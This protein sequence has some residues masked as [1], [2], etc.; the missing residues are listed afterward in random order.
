[1]KNSSTPLSSGQERL[2]LVQQLDRDSAAY[3][4]PI[5]LRFRDGIDFEVLDRALAALVERHSAL[6][7]VFVEDEAG[8]PVTR[9][10]PGFRVPVER[11]VAEDAEEGWRPHGEQ[12]AAEPF[13]L[14]AAPPVRALVVECG[15][16]SAVLC[17][18]VHHIVIDGRSIR[19]LIR[20][21]IALYNAE[22]LVPLESTYADFVAWQRSVDGAA[23]EAH[24]DHWRRELDGFEPLRLPLDRPRSAD[25]G[26][27]GGH[28]DFAL[29]AE[30]TATLSAL[31]LRN[32]CT[33][34]S[35]VAAVFQA[36][37]SL[38]SGQQ[39]VTT[40]SV[41]S[42]R[43]DAR[44]AD[45]V[46]FF[47][48]TVVLR[49]RIGPETCL[50]DL[51]KLAHLK[52]TAAHVHQQAP[53]DQVVAAVQPDRE[54]GSNA[55]FDVVFVHHGETS[56]LTEG[57]ISRV[58]WTAAAT[59][60]DLELSTH[61]RR[62]QLHGT[63]TFRSGLFHRATAVR[64]T[65]RFVTLVEQ[66]LLQPDVPISQLDLISADELA[67]TEA[68]WHS[69]RRAVAG[70]TVAALFEAQVERTPDAIAVVTR[71]ERFTYAQLDERA[72]R[73]A[74]AL[75]AAGA[76]AEDVIGVLAE[77]GSDV[78]TAF[79]AILKTGAAYLPLATDDPAVRTQALLREAG[80][81]LALSDE[82][83]REFDDVVLM[84]FG[85]EGFPV[86]APRQN[87]HPDQLAYVM[88]TSG[89]TG[90]PK[91]VAVSHRQVA[92]LALDRG[93]TEATRR[94]LH[95]SPHTFDA[96]TFEIWVPLLS[97][98]C[99]VLAAPGRL[100]AA[101]FERLVRQESVTCAWLT[102]GLFRVFADERPGAF[103]GLREVW[104]GGDV[105]PPDAVAEVLRRHRHLVVV[106]GYGPTETT[107]FAT[108]HRVRE[109]DPA[110]GAIP[111]G[112]PLDNT[113]CHVLN[114]NLRPVPEG[115]AGELFIA[116]TGVGRGYLGRPDLTATRFV[117]DP[118]GPP[119][120]RMYRSGDLA[121]WRSDGVLE[122]L[123]RA[124]GQVKIRGYRV[125]TG[126]VEHALASLPGIRQAVVVAHGDSDKVLVA[127]VVPESAHGL[128]EKSLRDSLGEVLPGHLVPSAFVL[129]DQVPV[130]PNGKVDRRAL[131]E[132]SRRGRT[133]GR[134]PRS[135][136]EELLC[137]LFA[138][139]LGEEAVGV[140]DD[141]FA[142]G[143][144]SLLAARLVNRVRVLFDAGL[145]VRDI[146]ENTTPARLAA[147]LD[148]AA[149]AR[150]A[151]TVRP[152]PPRVPLSSA[153]QR[154]WFIHQAQGPNPT[155]NIP[156]AQR[157]RGWLDAEALRAALLDVVDRHESL[158]TV[159]P[160]ENGTPHQV[161]LPL[162]EVDSERL[163][164]VVDVTEAV[165]QQALDVAARHSFDLR[166]DVPV[167]ARLFRLSPDDHVLLVLIH[168]I[169]GDGW[170]IGPFHRDL[171]TAY[172][173]RTAGRKPAW[174]PLPV[175]YADFSLWERDVLGEHAESA[176]QARY[177]SDQLAGLPVELALPVD[178]RR[179]TDV[180]SDGDRVPVD[181]DPELHG[182][183][184][185]LAV[186]RQASL[187]MV[188]QA[189][190]AVL[191]SKLGGGTDIPLGGVVAG[192]SDEAL[193][194]LIGFFVNAQVL[195][196]DLSGTPTFGEV[197]SEVRR[198]NLAAYHHQD[199]AFE[200]VVEIVSPPRMLTRHPLFQVVLAFQASSDTAFVVDGLT[201]E[202]MQAHVRTAKF[203]LNFS[204][205]ERTDRDGAPL[206][207]RGVLEYDTSLFD[208][209]TA[210]RISGLLVGLLGAL[211]RHA[212][213][214][215]HHADMGHA[216]DAQLLQ[217]WNDTAVDVPPSTLVELIE[218]QVARTPD[219][220]AVLFEDERLSFAELDSRANRLASLLVDRGAGPERFVGVALPRSVDLVVTLVAV[221]KAGAAY[222]PIET[223]QPV[224]RVAMLLEESTPIAVVARR[225]TAGDVPRDAPLVVIDDEHV[226]AALAA[227]TGNP[228]REPLSPQHPAYLIYT[229]GSTGRPKGVL[230]SHEAIVNRLEWMQ[231]KFG[232][233][234]DDRVLQKTPFGFDVS[235]W[236]FF[237]PLITGAALVVARPDGHRDPDYLATLIRTEGVTTVHFVPSM[238]QAF[239]SGRGAAGCTGLRRVICSGE[240]LPAALADRFHEILPVP[241]HNLYGPT[242]AA[243]DVTSWDCEPGSD[244]ASIPIGAPVWNTRT[245][246]LDPL[247]RPVPIGVQ[248]ELYLSGVQVARGYVGKPDLTAERFVAD[249]FGPPGSRMYRTGDV[250]RWTSGGALEY[251]G[252][253]DD[254]VKIRGM[255]VEPEEI[256][257]VLSAHEAV[258]HAV[259]VPRDN[260]LVA[261]VVPDAVNAGA[262]RDLLAL[263]RTGE[264][265]GLPSRE[266]PNGMV[267]LGRNNAEIEFLHQEIFERREY[268][269]YG[270][271]LPDDAVVF[272]IGAH[273]GLFSLF[274]AHHAPDAT[275]YAFEPIPDLARELRLNTAVNGVR[276]HLFEC[277]VGQTAGEA[278]F[279]Y[280]PQLSMLSG[281]FGSE[282]EERAVV[283]AYALRDAE[284][285][286]TA[287]VGDLVTERLRDRRELVCSLRAVS[288]VI[289]EHQVE[290]I[291]LLKVDAEK[292]ELEV[293]RGVRDEHWP[294]IRQVVAEVHDQG[295]RV[296]TITELLAGKGFVVHV[297]AADPLADSGLVNIFAVNEPRPAA[298]GVARPRAAGTR[299]L[300]AELKGAARTRLPE[301]MVPDDVVFLEAL[302]LSRNGKL[303][304]K[305]LPA[306]QRRP[307]SSS[308]GPANPVEERLCGLFAEAVGLEHVGVDDDFFDIGGH[309]LLAARLVGEI[310]SA[311]AVSL[312]IG[313]VFQAPT[314]ARLAALIDGGQLTATHDVLLPIRESG[315]GSPVF[316]F[317]PGIGLSWC[318]AGFAK[319]LRG[320]PIYGLQARAASDV[321]L[322]APSLAHMARD[323]LEQILV[324]QPEGPY[325]LV[326][327]SFGG[328]VAHTVASML[329]EAGHEVE[330]LA[331]IDGYPY[332]GRATRSP[333]RPSTPDLAMVRSRHLDGTALSEVDD[334]RAAE[335]A[336][337]LAHNTG[338]AQEHK[339]PLFDGDV[340]FFGAA[341]HRDAAELK[342]GAWQPFVTGTVRVHVVEAAH[343]EM[344]RPEPLASMAAVI[345]GELGRTGRV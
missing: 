254:Q 294:I 303:D 288:D 143:G 132:P 274:V 331:V 267:V 215:V 8:A 292:S 170:S 118:A 116:G 139:L 286:V 59:R 169:A 61:V 74:H 231:A 238:L 3:N 214:P 207:L 130:T 280:Y 313:H 201:A 117:A 40:G 127:Y 196:Y 335:L 147:V 103:A 263:S 50:R 10:V 140:D 182:V 248:G 123:G 239:L 268:L 212:D 75:I 223:G 256:S 67:R 27:A 171:A 186:R 279:T 192:R 188:L 251:L 4:V 16:G 271:T 226:V 32:R 164:G 341:G 110:A 324:A 96:A 174:S 281:R 152:R 209:A 326:G 72:N 55:I 245:H 203:D 189:G 101:E 125:E 126:E 246:V 219:A 273:V 342:P 311:L 220:D 181:I 234:S 47:V 106:N 328:N 73:L 198:T 218:R 138:E 337:V 205:S 24:V 309:S 304:R 321:T 155:Y 80:A 25:A 53:F 179:G 13:D 336:E 12:L 66:G 316:F 243:V 114:N 167:Q 7:G 94:V 5:A 85:G 204:F 83:S 187:C 260:R 26:F 30:L 108:T 235:V 81:R 158:R 112:T 35:A 23:V 289:A 160:A 262:V 190:L 305:A 208:Q 48:N 102:A 84:G 314:V 195:R 165:L 145:S 69:S 339:P 31:A 210:E 159:F 176:A 228:R 135:V 301:H 232:L 270:I 233:A 71:G 229:S 90:E 213:L 1:M 253:T 92:E 34:S 119:G 124:D 264:L 277:G 154:L 230:V 291:D 88:Y 333:G 58:P 137:T 87:V 95:H 11:R 151:V 272:D 296:D 172:Q 153:Q 99:V 318:Y 86:H 242:E 197:I 334:E 148:H 315:D 38:H 285:D 343:H 79:V 104:T 345:S 97:G 206:G 258:E 327:W 287:L 120:A 62:H 312:S 322:L 100:D 136:R 252:R 57:G 65:E 20:D 161:V 39:D 33:F 98:G 297:E 173:A 191:L 63:L 237:W 275:I 133:A 163:W 56:A 244:R 329:R 320:L 283:D 105:V 266:L 9:P 185:D 82:T 46:G 52:V 300:T 51:L 282:S 180:T 19:I 64:L 236:E 43:D 162:S 150:P 68:R 293:L 290:R 240:A 307:S 111:I 107:T 22:P 184:R 284:E 276:A 29:S 299:A 76:G 302:P 129:L 177:W 109:I 269:R 247:L 241:L 259:V 128:S 142:L 221:L 298:T 91:G 54:P 202:P 89:S 344:L 199:L 194:D 15:D 308:R 325:R 310:K 149:M 225:D 41:L 319:H 37:L 193:T 306:P 77:R 338:L 216:A 42:G 131:P 146:F 222:L 227:S 14:A 340:L 255:R 93:W 115:V 178:R 211:A 217:A 257:A 278:T 330:L 332:A 166:S 45:V 141:F 144:H 200:R 36:L 261:Y 175:Q 60:F 28:V 44:F 78:L 317:H 134:A 323:Y 156:V 49:T 265:D 122:F 113:R 2:W 157:L 224:D 295:D 17:L 6:A 70:E 250:A 18:V 183:L 21:L 121:R 249:P 168:H